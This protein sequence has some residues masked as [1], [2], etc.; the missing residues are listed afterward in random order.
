MHSEASPPAVD[1]AIVARR[2]P[3]GLA[4]ALERGRLPWLTP[5]HLPGGSPLEVHRIHAEAGRARAR[6]SAGASK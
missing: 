1:V 2:A 5:L 4:A 6:R 3:H